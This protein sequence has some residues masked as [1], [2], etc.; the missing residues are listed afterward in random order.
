MNTGGTFWAFG[1][2]TP[3]A[4]D[5]ALLQQN[6]T[7]EL[8]SQE[9]V[10]SISVIKNGVDSTDEAQKALLAIRIEITPASAQNYQPTVTTQ[11][12]TQGIADWLAIYN[13]QVSYAK[14]QGW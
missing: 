12:W 6:S 10:R 4:G 3:S 14:T 9:F 13:A 7:Y 5:T 2:Q 8:L 1:R 11:Y